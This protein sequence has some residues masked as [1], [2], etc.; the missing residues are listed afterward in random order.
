MKTRS[1]S[2]AAKTALLVLPLLAV[3]IPAQAQTADAP[4]W[5]GPAERILSHADALEL[6]A[7]QRAQLEQLAARSAEQRE[8]H[9][10]A[11]AE[12]SRERTRGDRQR[13]EMSPEMRERMRQLRTEL[14]ELA[15]EERRARMQE[16]RAEHGERG[17]MHRQRGDRQR[18]PAMQRRGQGMS[19]VRDILTDAQ[20]EA[21]R[22]LMR[23]QRGERRG[24]TGRDR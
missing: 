2:G 17:Q 20:H 6:T 9:R 24:R 3:G 23:E 4:R 1:I 10:E 13:P 7:E 18:A 14:S 16:L 11:R 19:E 8:A 12:R 21:L 5:Q 22:D 15:P